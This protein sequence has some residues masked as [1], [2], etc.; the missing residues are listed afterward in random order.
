MFLHR[1]R[2]GK[3][4]Q[5]RLYAC[6]ADGSDLRIVNPGPKV[7]H[8]DWRDDD[9][10]LAW[11]EWKGSPL[12]YRLHHL[13]TGEV[14]VFAPGLFDTD[15]HCHWRPV[16]FGEERRW[17]VTDTYPDKERMR[18]LILYDSLRGARYDVAR[19]LAPERFDGEIRCDL[20]PRWDL[21]GRLVTVDSLH[22]G[23][24]GIYVLD[25]GEIVGG[26]AKGA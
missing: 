15:G 7:S 17:L 12:S 25:A 4:W 21:S 19:F 5:T 3:Y 23:Y 8:C 26:E 18:T 16:P 9:T 14:E 10:I 20:H 2:V 24:R 22:E 6:R 11:C 13:D 1:W